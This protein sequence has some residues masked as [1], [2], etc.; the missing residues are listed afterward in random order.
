M[1]AK[2]N[3]LKLFFRFFFLL[4]RTKLI[5]DFAEYFSPKYDLRGEIRVRASTAVCDSEI[6]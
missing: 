2:A 5:M 6:F 4:F 3:E 1:R